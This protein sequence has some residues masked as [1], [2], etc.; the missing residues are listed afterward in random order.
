MRID[1]IWILG[2]LLRGLRRADYTIP[3]RRT[4]SICPTC[5]GSGHLLPS[6]TTCPNCNGRKTIPYHRPL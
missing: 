3:D 4:T 2:G 1:R 5:R 6:H